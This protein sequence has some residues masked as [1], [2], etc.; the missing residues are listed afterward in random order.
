MSTRRKRRTFTPEFKKQIVDLYRS[1][2]SRK[3]IIDDYDLTPSAFDKWVRQHAQSGSFKEKD[4][5]TPEQQELRELRK[6]NTQLKME[7]DI[8]KQAAL[9]FGRK[10]EVIKQ[11]KHKYSISAMCQVLGISRGS[12]YYEVKKKASE[13]DLEQAIIEEFAKS[14]NSYGTRKLKIELAKRG[15][16][17]SRRRIGRIMKKFNLVSNYVQRKY[18][19]HS[20]GTN[21]TQIDNLLDRDFDSDEPMKAIVTDLTYVNIADK[22]FYICFIIDLFNREIIGYSSGPNKTVDLVHQ[23]LATI[24]DDLNNIEIF[25]TDRGKEFDNHT[26]DDFLATF[27]IDRSLS[28]RGDPYDNAVA[29]STYKSLKIEFIYQHTFLSLYELQYHLM[30][31]VNWWNKYRIHGSLNYCSPVDYKQNWLK[32]QSQKV[33]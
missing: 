25:H 21:Q 9:I 27:N 7:N 2:K 4:N 8:L 26:I 16:T 23:A 18:K 15:F 1:G 31:Y 3:E 33:L 30:D 19:V 28:H 13:A 24:K 5:L 14:R 12:Y 22:W 29:E 32:Q 20:K 10:L 17:V 11:N 6:E